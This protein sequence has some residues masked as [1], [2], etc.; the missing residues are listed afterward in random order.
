M[1]RVARITL[2]VVLI[3]TVYS[4]APVFSLYLKSDPVPYTNE[5]AA[6]KLKNNKGE[7]FAF[8]VFGDCHSGFIFDD[9]ATLKL[10]WHMN[11]EDRF[12]KI[13][14]D[15]AASSG[16]ISFRGS[17]WDYRIYNRIRSLI[18]W[19]VISAIGN[20]D[21]DKDGLVFFKKY[22]GRAEIS[23]ADRNAYFIFLDNRINNVSE[24]QFARLEVELKKSLAYT[25]RFIILHKSPLSPY[26]QSW[27]RPELSP[28]SYRFMKMC[29]NYKVDIVFSGHEHMSKGDTYGDVKYLTSGGGGMITQFPASEGGVLHYVVVRVYGDYVDYEVRKIFP[30]LWEFLIYYAWKEVFYFLKDVVF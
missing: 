17:E 7:H 27:Y 28:W 24:E 1:K 22:I 6:E 16:D 26:Q 10:I 20:H 3:L 15:F 11:R 4:M 25:H 9:S 14:I 19:P 23:F 12:K 29:Q 8:I 18:K 30:P 21:T 2:I 5:Q 13:P